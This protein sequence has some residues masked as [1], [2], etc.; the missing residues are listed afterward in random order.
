AG[1]MRTD[2]GAGR[3]A[4]AARLEPAHDAPDCL[5]AEAAAATEDHALDGRDQM[6]RIEIVQP[7]NVVRTAP[8]LG[9]AH[10]RAVAQ[11]HSDAGET[12]EIGR[13]TDANARDVGTQGLRL[14]PAAR[15]RPAATSAA[16]SIARWA[17]A[18]ASGSCVSELWPSANA[19]AA[20]AAIAACS[21]RSV[22][23][24]TQA[25]SAKRRLQRRR[26]SGVNSRS[27]TRPRI[28]SWR[29]ALI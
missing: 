11:D 25:I 15:S 12:G 20:A 21:L 27:I 7:D 19:A 3:E 1:T 18:R 10:S 23:P 29:S 2:G 28:A 6:A 5:A 26:A 22:A 14:T 9:A 24:N 17:S 8:E 16:S 13:L 4:A